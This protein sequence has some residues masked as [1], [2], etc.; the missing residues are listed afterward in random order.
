M[1]LDKWLTIILKKKERKSWIKNFF[2]KT[3]EKKT[4]FFNKIEEKKEKKNF[5]KLINECMKIS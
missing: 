4:I 2:D 5:L 1:E 3:N